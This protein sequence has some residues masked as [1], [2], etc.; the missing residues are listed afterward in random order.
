MRRLVRR[1][2]AYSLAVSAG[3]IFGCLAQP[4]VGQ[5]WFSTAD[6]TRLVEGL[7]NG[8]F[9][10][11]YVSKECESDIVEGSEGDNL[12]QVMSTYLEVP[13]PLAQGA[14]CRALVQAIIDDELTVEGLV[15]VARQRMDA[16]T[17]L[18]VG[19]IL[20]AVYFAHRRMT[21]AS[22]EG[23]ELQ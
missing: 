23:Q 18:E 8:T 22:I 9:S 20:R 4:A 12:R 14:F 7:K 1:N 5:Q 19:R 11:A 15:K 10:P 6:I 2:L 17:F 13:E 3:L 16:G 21:T